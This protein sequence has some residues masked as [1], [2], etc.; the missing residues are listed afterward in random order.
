MWL[1]G[2]LPSYLDEETLSWSIHFCVL[3]KV[4]VC[5]V[6]Y[7]FIYYS[8]APNPNPVFISDFIDSRI[9][10]AGILVVLFQ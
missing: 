8:P 6:T 2:T 9:N 5:G 1:S 10:F 3:K 4:C 7:I